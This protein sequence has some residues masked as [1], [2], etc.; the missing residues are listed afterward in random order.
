[1]SFSSGARTAIGEALSWVAAATLL[2]VGVVYFDDVK[3]IVAHSLGLT[4]PDKVARSH[5]IRTDTAGSLT[6]S[7]VR[8]TAGTR[9]ELTAGRN[10][11]FYA[12][13]RINGRR[14]PVLVD[15]GASFVALPYQAAE[16]A[17]IF[18]R[19]SDFKHRVQTANGTARIAIV[20]VDE[21]DIGGIVVRNVRAA[22]GQPGAMK[23]TLLGMSFLGR[24]HRA[25][26]S[27]G[28]LVLEN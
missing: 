20:S 6:A 9:V 2:L 4:P 17:G 3:R 11:H 10:G 1:M 26:I 13:A 25:E 15:T 23:I 7:E 28:R 27:R 18:V 8:P 21:I 12:D 14:T 22:I 24:L 19:D 16:D 5:P